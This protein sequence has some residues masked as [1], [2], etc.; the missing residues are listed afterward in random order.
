ML[1]EQ[2]IYGAVRNGHGLRCA[3]G[4]QK[5]ATELASRLD[6]P[7]TAPPG[8]HWSPYVS[9]FA[10]RDHYVLAKTFSDPAAS[11][12]GMV[13]THALICSLDR[14]VN[15]NDLRPVFQRLISDPAEAPIAVETLTIAVAEEVSPPLPELADAARSLVARA[16]GPVVRIG[17]EGFEDLVAALW[18][19]MWPG[20]RQGFSFRL[21][22]GPGDIVEQPEPTLVCT[23]A[24]LI[25]RWQQQRIIGRNGPINSLAAAMI[26]GSETG[27]PLRQF[28]DRIGAKLDG[29]EDLPLLE[30]A[31]LMASATPESVPRLLAAVRL[32]ERLSPDP[33]DGEIEKRVIIDRLVSVLPK[34]A[35][36][37]VLA[38]RNMAFPGFAT[39][40]LIW[41]GLEER[42]VRSS[43]P[44]SEDADLCEILHDALIAA[45]AQQP[46]RDAVTRG[47]KEAAH[48]ASGT[49]QLGFWRWAA[50]DPTVSAPLIMLVHGDS[51]AVEGLVDVAPISLPQLAAKPILASSAEFE[52]FRLH[53]VAASASMSPVDAARTQ[54]AVEPGYDVAAMRLALRRAK[55]TELL[56]CVG[57]VDDE[58][59]LRIAGERVAK[60]P[61]L[62]ANRD[63]SSPANR[64]IWVAALE[65]NPESW[66][67]PTDP[68]RDFD[69]ILGEQ[70]DGR[71]P[72]AQLLEHLSTT[73]LADLSSFARRK[74]LW[75]H[76]QGDVQQRLLDATSDKWFERAGEESYDPAVEPEVERR[77]LRDRR[78]DRLLDQLSVGGIAA[79][80]RLIAALPGL[81]H[82]RIRN[83]IRSAVQSTRP[84]STQVADLVGQSV[85]ARGRR[86]VVDDLLSIYRSGR[87]DVGPALRHCLNLMGFWDRLSL[88]ISPVTDTEKLESFVQ[89]ASELY[90][91]GP[92]H[93]SLWERAGGRDSDLVHHGSGIARWRAALKEIQHGKPPRIAQLVREMRNDFEGNSKL[94]LLAD[95]PLFNR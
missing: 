33:G 73:P 1:I 32:V 68:R 30:K 85:A 19:R 95:D 55:P 71:H 92:D 35:P 15:T 77:L 80:L 39:G 60:K 86:D 29:F 16:P 5:L 69:Q 37:E 93:N 8:A 2:A 10:H 27:V 52:L 17:T 65:A 56:D 79:G 72:P 61:S 3:S 11:R 59:V 81:E 36:S 70:I 38:L 49:F 84:L 62:L 75:R 63:M 88:G 89:L 18:S 82:G 90:P 50:T 51:R 94:P 42:L 67:G 4:D 87:Q 43:Y 76:V 45:H 9:G 91:G 6:L 20:L 53:A 46:W 21:S 26:D 23:P 74:D 14:I 44:Q 13:L 25:G 40:G 31:Y 7:D 66:R 57:E 34:S 12:A 41:R 83:W 47:L 78:L 48:E 24:S 58:R 28:A 54:S 22:F 64:R